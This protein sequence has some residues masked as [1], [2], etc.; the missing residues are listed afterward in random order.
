MEEEKEEETP[1]PVSTS[2]RSADSTDAVASFLTRR[3]GSPFPIL[4]S[5]KI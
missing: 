1:P 5:V 4:A 3:F 2:K